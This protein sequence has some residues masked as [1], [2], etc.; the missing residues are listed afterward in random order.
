ML[1]MIHL[2]SE[3]FFLLSQQFSCFRTPN[4]VFT[5]KM[6]STGKGGLETVVLKHAETGASAEVYLLGAHVTS[7]VP[8]AGA[9]TV[10]VL[11]FCFCF[12]F[13]S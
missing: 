11:Y 13:K 9:P 12:C 7:F 4:K 3:G 10:Q 2:N 1:Y 6:R 5:K 8:T